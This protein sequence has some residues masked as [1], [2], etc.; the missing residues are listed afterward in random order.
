MSEARYV[1]RSTK[2]AARMVGDE[3]MIMSGR[4]ATLFALNGAAAMIW[5]SADGVT[6]ISTIV[7]RDICSAFDVDPSVALADAIELVAGLIEA[8]LMTESPMPTGP[9]A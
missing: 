1:T 3:L 8:G 4:D 7:E 6:P 2:V 5:N 9:T